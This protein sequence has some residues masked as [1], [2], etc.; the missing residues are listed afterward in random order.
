MS[1][2]NFKFESYADFW[3]FRFQGAHFHFCAF[4]DK[5]FIFSHPVWFLLPNF[6]RC[7]LSRLRQRLS[8]AQM[9]RHAL[10]ALRDPGG[11]FVDFRDLSG[12]NHDH[13]GPVHHDLSLI[14][15]SVLPHFRSI[16][17]NGVAQACAKDGFL[18]RS[19]TTYKGYLTH[20]ETSCLLYTSRCV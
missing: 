11:R 6:R 16:I 17:N 1:H 14:H 10:L 15:I 9:N 4:A 19:L 18:R 20:E 12:R 3:V 2:S 8:L 7:Q 13:A 5:L